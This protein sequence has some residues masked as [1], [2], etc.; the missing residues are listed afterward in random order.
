[1][2]NLQNPDAIGQ[3]NVRIVFSFAATSVAIAAALTT[4]FTI[5]NNADNKKLTENIAFGASTISLAA[6]VTGAAYAL[7]S[8]RHSS[9]Q[10]HESR[11]IDATRAYIDQWD[12]PQFAQ[13][14]ITIRELQQMNSG[15][16]NNK[17]EQLRDSIK[18]KPNAQQDITLILNLLEKI[19]L[20]WSAGLLHEPLLKQ[21][22][23]P[24][25]LQCWEILRVYVSDRRNE[26]G[27]DLFTHIEKLYTAWNRES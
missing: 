21:F 3:F 1:M 10:Q 26:R 20:C 5:A 19:A 22:Y 2:N 27:D 4:A 14:R 25:V 7:Q 9:I 16:T 11:R 8:L 23:R 13:A 12:E 18:Q 15:N 24:I 6:G 17:S